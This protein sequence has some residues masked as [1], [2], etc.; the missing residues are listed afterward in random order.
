VDVEVEKRETG[1]RPV[2]AAGY[3]PGDAERLHPVVRK[4]LSGKLPRLVEAQADWCVL[5]L[6]LS[7]TDWE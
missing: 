2:S 1:V 6:E 7:A 4:A 5:L 3:R